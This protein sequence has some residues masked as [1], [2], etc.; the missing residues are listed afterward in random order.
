MRTVVISMT[1]LSISLVSYSWYLDFLS[2]HFVT[3]ATGNFNVLSTKI[4]ALHLLPTKE[5]SL[6]NIRK[7]RPMT[8]QEITAPVAEQQRRIRHQW[9]HWVVSDESPMPPTIGFPRDTSERRR[10]ASSLQKAELESRKNRKLKPTSS[11][12]VAT[13]VSW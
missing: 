5:S 6:S 11:C 12:Q 9:R 10:L 3:H 8:I 7:W 13:Y 2:S 1:N 4:A